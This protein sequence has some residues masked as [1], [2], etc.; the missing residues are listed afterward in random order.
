MVVKEIVRH[1]SYD[2]LGELASLSAR[3]G[4]DAVV[5]LFEKLRRMNLKK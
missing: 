2:R 4:L 5:Q 3:F 1:V